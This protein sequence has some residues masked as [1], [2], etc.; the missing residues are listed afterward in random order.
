MASILCPDCGC[1][2]RRSHS[3][4]VGEKLVR[5][6]SSYRAYRCHECGWRGWL[7]KPNDPLRIRLRMSIITALLAILAAVIIVLVTLRVWA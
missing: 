5:A 4:G 6:V 2:L 1:H 3:H 7:T